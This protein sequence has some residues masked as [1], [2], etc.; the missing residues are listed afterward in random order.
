MRFSLVLIVL[1]LLAAGAAAADDVQMQTTVVPVV[2]SVFG[3]SM[4]RWKTDLEVVN[5]TGSDT[6]VALELASAPESPAILFT[7]GRGQSQR[8]PDLIA[9]AFGLDL[10][11]S[12]LRVTNSGRRAVTLH[13]NVYAVMG[14]ETS[15]LQ[16]I[17]VYDSRSV[18]PSRVLD[19]LDFSDDSR[20]NIG[21]VNFG[22]RDA[23]FVLA[24]QRIPG[25]NVAVSHLR[26][27]SGALVHIAIQSVFPLI[28]KGTGFTVVVETGAPDT[29]VYA[30]V[31]ESAT[32]AGRFVAARIGSH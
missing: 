7:L 1:S 30:S 28:S 22:E 13:A 8:F 23:D 5:D 31:I 14:T 9:N 29:Y 10:A 25:R 11:L 6:D 26:V 17:A 2:G 16:P 32:N 27:S 15:P 12:P 18:Y 3:P 24:L 21:L 20:T 4:I 19:N